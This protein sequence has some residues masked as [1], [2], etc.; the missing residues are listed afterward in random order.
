MTDHEIWLKLIADLK[1]ENE[2][3][4]AQLETESYNY[5]Q[6]RNAYNNLLE[7]GQTK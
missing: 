2:T 1:R 3:L 7:E 4:K 6:L 5:S